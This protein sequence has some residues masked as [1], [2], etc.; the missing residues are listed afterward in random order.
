MS[1][2]TRQAV[3]NT[4]E[5]KT[6]AECTTAWNSQRL[7]KKKKS[8]PVSQQGLKK[9]VLKN[10]KMIWYSQWTLCILQYV[11]LVWKSSLLKSLETK[12]G[13]WEIRIPENT[14]LRAQSAPRMVLIAP[15]FFWFAKKVFKTIAVTS[16]AYGRVSMLHIEMMALYFQK[17]RGKKKAESFYFCFLC[18]LSTQLEALRTED[19]NCPKHVT[20]KVP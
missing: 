3:A 11:T 19:E 2:N 15:F 8:W 7:T 12:T 20:K 17:E 4:I 6:R 9:K 1:V 18:A 13:R 14:I 10:G 5:Y 16:S